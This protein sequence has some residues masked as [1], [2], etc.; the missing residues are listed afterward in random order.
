[1]QISRF[2][3]YEVLTRKFKF[4]TEFN[5]DA[6]LLVSF[7]NVNYK[8]SIFKDG[9]L[10]V[11][12]ARSDEPKYSVH[13]KH[14][15]IK[16]SEDAKLVLDE[17]LIYIMRHYLRNF[18]VLTRN[19][20]IQSINKYAIKKI[21]TFR[22]FKKALNYIIKVLYDENRLFIT[23]KVHE[24]P[25][26]LLSKKN[27]HIATFYPVLD[28][29]IILSNMYMFD[30][31]IIKD[32]IEILRSNK[33]SKKLFNDLCVKIF[34]KNLLNTIKYKNKSNLFIYLKSLI[35]DISKFDDLVNALNG[36]KYFKSLYKLYKETE[37]IEM[38][39]A[40]DVFTNRLNVLLFKSFFNEI[41]VDKLYFSNY[42]V[43]EFINE[44]FMQVYNKEYFNE[45]IA[46]HIPDEV[47]KHLN[48]ELNIARNIV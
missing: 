26:E 13:L 27:K 32:E 1:M 4:K 21:N 43:Y 35:Y 7:Y 19:N 36:S 48:M 40:I 15:H 3:S 45:L 20:I 47:E 24:I 46:A 42:T 25:P 17:F 30:L 16:T 44:F 37:D 28:L 29:I 38:Y 18:T 9:V 11:Y 23:S 5:N 6:M 39:Y 22:E 8:Y 12:N 14:I 41:D 33:I 10:I 34:D 31:N 2:Y